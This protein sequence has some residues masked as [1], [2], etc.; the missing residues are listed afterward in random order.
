LSEDS[1]P[2]HPTTGWR[3]LLPSSSIRRP[4]GDHLAAGL[5]RRE[6]DGLTTFRGWITDGL[7][8]ACPPVAR[9]RRQGKGDAPAPGHVP[10]W[11]QP[12]SVFGLSVLTTFI[13]SSPE[14]ALPSTL[15][16]DRLG[17][18]SRRVPSR[19]IR[20]PGSGEDTLF[21]E[22]R[23]ARLLRPHVLVGYRW[24]HTGLCPGRKTSQ[25]RYIRS[26]VSQSPQN[27]P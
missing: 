23:T 26:F 24:S 1:T 18:S 13:G 14:L 21:Q 9:Q 3:S 25:N 19:E 11:F 16:P 27:C 7:G 10:F 6:D 22:L 17:A 4:I 8:S 5:P 15:V 20:P 2:I 12:V